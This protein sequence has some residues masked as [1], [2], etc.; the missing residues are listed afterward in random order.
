M[1]KFRKIGKYVLVVLISLLTGLV[2]PNHGSTEDMSQMFTETVDEH[3]Q[4]HPPMVAPLIVPTMQMEIQKYEQARLEKEEAKWE[5]VFEKLDSI[6]L[7]LYTVSIG[8]LKSAFYDCRTSNDVDKIVQA[9]KDKPSYAKL[10]YINHVASYD[11]ARDLLKSKLY[12]D[13]VFNALMSHAD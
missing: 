5:Q 13:E 8:T 6:Q 3:G 9:W 11:P 10:E 4:T 2:I 1:E 12:S 7:G